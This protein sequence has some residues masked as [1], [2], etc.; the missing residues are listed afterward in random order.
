MYIFRFILKSLYSVVVQKYANFP[1]HFKNI[2][3]VV[4]QKKNNNHQTN[5]SI[6]SFF[7]GLVF[8]GRPESI[9]HSV[10]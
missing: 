7:Q 8:G 2:D 9:T 4:V 10:K 5:I 3:S 6:L 1:V